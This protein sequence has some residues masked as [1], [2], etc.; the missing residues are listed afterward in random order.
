[1][2]SSVVMVDRL[3]DSGCRKSMER[4]MP[5]FRSIRSMSGCCFVILR[6]LGSVLC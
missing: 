2:V 3:V 4:W 1:M 5:E 6:T